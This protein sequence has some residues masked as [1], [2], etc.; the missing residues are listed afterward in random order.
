MSKFDFLEGHTSGNGNQIHNKVTHFIK[1]L[2]AFLKRTNGQDHSQ[3]LSTHCDN[4]RRGLILQ[5][6][7]P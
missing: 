5:N 4:T 3:Q 1:G 7:P 2:P 6:N